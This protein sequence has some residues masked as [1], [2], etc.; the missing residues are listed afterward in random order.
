[1]F[2]LKRIQDPSN[3]RPKHFIDGSRTFLLGLFPPKKNANN[4]AEIEAEMIKQYFQVETIR[5]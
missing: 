4:V 3:Y 2:I 1:V 5:G